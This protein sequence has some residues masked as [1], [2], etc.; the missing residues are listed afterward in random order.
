MT[1]RCPCWSGTG[2]SDCQGERGA[3]RSAFPGSK[4]QSHP[5]VPPARLIEVEEIWFKYKIIGSKRAQKQSLKLGPESQVLRDI[6]STS[7]INSKLKRSPL[8]RLLKASTMCM[9][10]CLQ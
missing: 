5:A 9:L 4:F 2:V 1:L 6:G 8:P 7:G 3:G 10:L